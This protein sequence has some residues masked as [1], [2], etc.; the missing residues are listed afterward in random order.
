ML[1]NSF[2]VRLVAAGALALGVAGNLEAQCVVTSDGSGT[3]CFPLLAGQT[4]DA[5]TVCLSIDA[6][7]LN[8]TYSTTG[9]WELTEAH[10]WVGQTLDDLPQTKTGNPIPGKFPYNSG[11]ITGLTSFTFS[12]PLTNPLIN[13]SCPSD[14]VTFLLA[15]HAALRKPNGDGTFQ[16]ETGWSDGSPITTK[17]NWATFST[18]TLSCDCG[19]GEAVTACE[20]AFAFGGASARC[21]EL[22]GFNRWGWTNGPL[23]QGTYTFDLYAGAGQCDLSKGTLVG[24]VTINYTGTTVTVTYT[25]TNGWWATETHVYVGTAKYPQFKQGKQ[26]VDTVAPGQ[27]PYIHGELDDV[28]TDTYN[29]GPFSGPIQVIAHAGVC[30]L[31]YE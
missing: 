7:A 31:V 29:L 10:L 14:D 9:G 3:Q 25:M 18:F 13:F 5:G 20:T 15:A 11:D 28:T 2:L 8:V 4:I 21:F 23:N 19:G 26:M 1:S 24:S 27:Y 30:H 16:T 12:I 6:G 17:G 22:D